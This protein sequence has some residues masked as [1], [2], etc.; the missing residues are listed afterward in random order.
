MSFIH[1]MQACATHT[2]THANNALSRFLPVIL[3]NACTHTHT[4]THTH[5]CLATISWSSL[6][7]VRERD[8]V[9]MSVLWPSR[10]QWICLA[11]HLLLTFPSGIHKNSPYQKWAGQSNNPLVLNL[12]LPK[13]SSA[14][15]SLHLILRTLSYVLEKIC[16]VICRMIRPTEYKFVALNPVGPTT[17]DNKCEERALKTADT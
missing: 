2:H 1:S 14:F 9:G 10:L 11:A 15:G 16:V 12:L 5:S 7:Y 6:F 17:A 8:A 3:A 4:Y 13:G